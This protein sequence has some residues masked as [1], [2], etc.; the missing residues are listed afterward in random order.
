MMNIT[1]PPALHGDE[2]A[3]LTQI[4]RYLFRLS[5]SLNATALTVEN[6]AAKASEAVAKAAGVDPAEV[7][8]DVGDQY[9]ALVSLVVKTANIV[10]SQM[11][12][13]V[14]TLNSKYKASGEFGELTEEVRRF[15][16]TTA[17]HTIENYTYNSKV[18][19]IPEM[20]AD[21][22]AYK[23]EA[24]GYI[25]RG[26]ID[27][28]KD[29]FPIFGI[30]IGQE[31]KSREVTINGVVHTEFDTTKNMATYTADKL[32]FWI[33][34]VEV[35]YLSQSELVVT[36]IIVSD[37]I[38]LGD[39]DIKVNAQDGLTIQQRIGNE[40]VTAS[41]INM[42]A[43]Q[44]DLSGNKSIKL[45]AEQINA[46]ANEI[47][48][49][50]NK[51][52]KLTAEQINAVAGQIDLTSNKSITMLAG[53]VDNLDR[54]SNIEV[55][56]GTFAQTE[57]REGEGIRIYSEIGP[58]QDLKWGAPWPGGAGKN[59]F[60]DFAA[61]VAQNG[62]TTTRNADG[63]HHI[64]GTASA[65]VVFALAVVGDKLSLPPGRYTASLGT[66]LP[67]GVSSRVE[68]YDKSTL[69][70]FKTYGN[71]PASSG[72]YTIDI[73][74]NYYTTWLIA[75]QAGVTVDFTVYPMIR[76]ASVT[77]ATYAPYAN[78]PPIEGWTGL[79]AFAG[80]KNLLKNDATSQTL[81]GMT[82]TVNEDGSVTVNGTSTATS[83]PTLSNNIIPAGR[84][85]LSGC[86][87]GGAYSGDGSYRLQAD[88]T[89]PDGTIKH[90][91]DIGSGTAFTL[92]ETPINVSVFIILAKNGVYNRLTF[93][94]MLRVAPDG[95]ATFQPYQG[96]T[97]V[98]DCGETVYGGKVDWHAGEI[99]VEWG[100]YTLTGTGSAKL[101]SASVYNAKCFMS[102]V[103]P[104]VVGNSTILSGAKSSH[105]V[106]GVWNDVV[107]MASP[108]GKFSINTSNKI[109]IAYDGTIDEAN[110]WLAAQ[111][112]SGTPVQF[113]LKLAEPYTIQ[114]APVQIETL[115]GI[116][117][118]YTDADGGRVELG[119]SPIEDIQNAVDALEEAQAE[120]AL[121]LKLDAENKVVRIGQTEVTSEF[122]IDAYGAGVVVGGKAFSRFE[123]ERMLIGGMEMRKPA[124]IGG[125]AFDSIM[126]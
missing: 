16:E 113:A 108:L 92:D 68:A 20:A 90:I 83:T 61:P 120:S 23:I 122:D 41:Q 32:S 118:V 69:K 59:L 70:W 19:N 80:G 53:E 65:R 72:E 98:L 18:L 7:S 86:P 67:D 101:I 82:I 88:I 62:I 52:I 5:E 104:G 94:P 27:Y 10:Q 111:N 37:S 9:T 78:T 35:A 26:I 49:S 6:Q 97:Y 34:G 71:I 115:Q 50:G 48:L 39:W 95:D 12:K 121:Y 126:T 107:N 2:Q 33:D 44:I 3:K 4:Y 117:T 99:T 81:N 36:R 91:A 109:G 79:N 31:L 58:K 84:Y 124:N 110:A 21:F 25:K 43:D 116:N 76:L 87:A 105:F 96:N 42:V 15:I 77:D 73:D 54:L 24:E 57:R 102:D 1:P 74:G 123:G 40:I 8:A 112:A 100:I 75:I 51:T 125:L 13:I 103:I 93:H 30:A 63:S 29:G 11:D 14:T 45:T 22:E 38:Q 46:V 85:I 17:K 56:E 60:P 89:M 119:H 106:E 114:F 66:A 28:D 55:I 47:D 64:S